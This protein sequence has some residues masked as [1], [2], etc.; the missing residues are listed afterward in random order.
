[1]PETVLI[2]M[3]SKKGGAFSTELVTAMEETLASGG[4]TLLFL[5][6]RGYATYL[7]CQ[8]CGHTFRCPNCAVSLTHHRSKNR[9]YCHYC[10]YSIPAPSLCPACSG[11][12]IVLLG[13][14]TEKVE[15]EV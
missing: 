13:R 8:D 15:D 1:M 3:R 7:V 14:G 11:G 10:D 12:D 2:E 9:H 5:N 4:Q 6:R